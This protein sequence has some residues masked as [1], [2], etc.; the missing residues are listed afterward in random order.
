MDKK[1]DVNIENVAVLW[2]SLSGYLT[3]CLKELKKRYQV[4]LLVIHLPINP[5]A[6]FALE[7]FNW[8]D[9]RIEKKEHITVDIIRS[10]LLEFQPDVILMGG[11]LRDKD[12]LKITRDKSFSK[13]PII[14]G[15]DMPWKGT[16]RQHIGRIISPFY[17]RPSIDYMWVPGDRQADF[18]RK[19]GYKGEKLWFGL[20]CCDTK[21]FHRVA[22]KKF[23]VYEKYGKWPSSFLF[24]GRYVESKGLIILLQSYQHY[25]K[26]V[27]NP[28]SLTCVGTGP[29]ESKLD[30]FAGVQNLGFVQPSELTSVYND[31]G[32]FVLPSLK[33]PWGVV[34]HE[35]VSSGIPVIATSECGSVTR[36]LCDGFNGFE[37]EAGNW[38]LLAN[39]LKII[40]SMSKQELY[41]MGKRSYQLSQQITTARWADYFIERAE[42][43]KS[44]KKT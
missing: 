11:W 17:L 8:I 31:A 35:A 23:D 6:P 42:N 41:N 32:T 13:I 10:K 37:I 7:R 3:A 2:T 44:I 34:L 24:V 15:M 19:L 4:K 38:K 20:Y 25:R 9:I 39:K 33:E 12:Y 40:S 14:G 21:C 28:W 22:V 29:L 43:A 27:S 1:K 30:S 36:F 18:A 16:L 26:M 5:E